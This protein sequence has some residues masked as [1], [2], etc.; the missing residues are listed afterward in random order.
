MT[1]FQCDISNKLV[2]FRDDLLICIS[3]IEPRIVTPIPV[4]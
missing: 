4:G 2:S 1:L 3:A